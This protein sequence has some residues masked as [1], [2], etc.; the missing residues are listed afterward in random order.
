[1]NIYQ[2]VISLRTWE[3]R[4]RVISKTVHLT[5]AFHTIQQ[6]HCFMQDFFFRVT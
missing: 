5:C 2:I 6:M 3:N 1:M 4:K